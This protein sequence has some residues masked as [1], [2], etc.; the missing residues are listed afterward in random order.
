MKTDL[1]LKHIPP[2]AIELEEEILSSCLLGDAEKVVE[3]LRPEDFYRTAH[4]KIF[5]IICDLTNRKIQVDLTST[6]DA[7]RDVDKLENIGGASYLARLTNEIPIAL[8]IEHYARKIKDKAVKRKIIEQCSTIITTCYEDEAGAVEILDNAQNKILSIEHDSVTESA[9]SYRDLSLKAGERYED[10]YKRR[11]AITGIASGFYML[12]YITCGF[13]NTDLIITAGRPSMGKTALALNIAGNVGKQD[14]PVAYFSL[15]MSKTQLFDRQ[16]A[17]ESGVNSQKFRSGKFEKSDWEAIANVQGKV[18]TWPIFIDDSPSL[19]YME[20]R[21]RARNLKKRHGIKLLII[22]HLQLVRGDKASSRDREIGSIT[23]GL[24]ATAKELNIPVILLSQLNR[25][26]EQRSNPRKRP[27]ISDLR[28]SGNIEQDSDAVMFL[29]RPK[30]YEDTEEFNGHTE[31]NIAK[32]R[33]G[34]TGMIKLRWHEKI[35]KFQNLETKR[36]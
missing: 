14:I 6:M 13:Q 30:V 26:L 23:A 27:I 4:Q 20:I 31:L 22:D 3:L 29:Y 11:G 15:E 25:Q 34:P 35:T 28:D 18:Y 2:Q 33:N 32:Q 12:D 7:L 21:R 19:H 9:I 24:K 10:L 5:S 16:V 36:D 17:G 1:S 8:N